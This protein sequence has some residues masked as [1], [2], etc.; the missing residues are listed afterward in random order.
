MVYTR[1]C[2]L[3][4]LQSADHLTSWLAPHVASRGPG[5]E[6]EPRACHLRQ[7]TQQ[8]EQIFLQGPGTLLTV[9]RQLLKSLFPAVTH[10]ASSPPP[11]CI[12]RKTEA[13]EHSPYQ[14]P[15][16]SLPRPSGRLQLQRTVYSTTANKPC[17]KERKKASRRGASIPAPLEGERRGG[18]ECIPLPSC[19][20]GVSALA[21]ER[22]NE[23]RPKPLQTRRHRLDNAQPAR[24]NGSITLSQTKV[25]IDQKVFQ[26]TRIYCTKAISIV[27]MKTL[28]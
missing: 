7:N 6:P 25:L 8:H 5:Q 24:Q 17:T 10:P 18:S 15:R 16:P 3:Y 9:F 22:G 23:G 12:S 28:W 13:A 11:S 1:N 19:P 21:E 4:L 20:R 2:T 26:Y 27:G 14:G